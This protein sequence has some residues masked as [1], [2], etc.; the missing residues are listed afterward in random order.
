MDTNEYLAKV[1]EIVKGD[2]YTFRRV[3]P[4]MVFADGCT[5]SVQVSSTHYCVPRRDDAH[6]YYEVEVGFP[7]GFEM[8]ASF[9]E[10]RD[11]DSHVWGYVPTDEIDALIE[12][13]GGIVGAQTYK[14]N[15]DGGKAIPEIEMF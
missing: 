7:E 13:H 1:K 8:P 2:S 5:L 4:R 3:A 10:H 14:A 9:D 12:Q 11:G 6:H 15:P